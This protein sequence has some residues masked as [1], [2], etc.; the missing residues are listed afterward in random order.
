L[1]GMR[2]YWGAESNHT[3]RRSF[4]LVVYPRLQI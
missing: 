2:L 4:R 3:Y 1:S